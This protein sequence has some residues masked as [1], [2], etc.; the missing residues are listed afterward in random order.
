MPAKPIQL[1]A[2]AVRAIE[3]LEAHAKRLDVSLG[4]AAV[5]LIERALTP[6]EPVSVPPTIA[7]IMADLNTVFGDLA[8][9][10]DR[11]DQ[12]VEVAEL[13]ARAETA[14][15]RLAALRSALEA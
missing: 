15:R 12:S 8:A 7:T 11:P 6:P 14:E 10:A 5:S 4:M 2:S 13:T 1:P 9:R 3:G